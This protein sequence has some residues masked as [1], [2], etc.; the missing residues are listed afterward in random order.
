MNRPRISSTINKGW[1]FLFISEIRLVKKYDFV[2]INKW[3]SL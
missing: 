1:G 2:R 3:V